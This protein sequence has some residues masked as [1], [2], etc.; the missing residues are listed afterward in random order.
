MLRLVDGYGV[1]IHLEELQSYQKQPN[2]ASTEQANI[3]C[4]GLVPPLD[5]GQANIPCPGLVPTLDHGQ[6]N[7]PCPGVVP[8]LDHGQMF[9]AFVYAQFQ[10]A[11]AR[12]VSR[13]TQF[14]LHWPFTRPASS[15]LDHPPWITIYAC[16][17]C[18]QISK[19]RPLGASAGQSSHKRPRVGAE[20]Q[21]E[22]IRDCLL[23]PPEYPMPVCPCCLLESL[24]VHV[25]RGNPI[26]STRHP[27]ACQR[28]QPI[29]D[30]LPP[31]PEHPVPVRLHS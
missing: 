26:L 25:K 13:P 14:T 1:T 20:P 3:P 29:C 5:H 2:L 10:E 8:T 31:P 9:P 17:A 23:P 7:I 19:K 24:P 18:V 28:N 16:F 30:C 4:P 12:C 15:A 21:A 22:T 27:C 11:D 6:A